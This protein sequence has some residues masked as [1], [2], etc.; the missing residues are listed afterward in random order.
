[1][2]RTHPE[3]PALRITNMQITRTIETSTPVDKV[4]AYL[5]DFTTTNE[6]DPGT[7]ETRRIKGD[8]GVGTDYR[9]TS[10]F[11]GRETEL[12]YTTKELEPGRRIVLEGNNK[13]VRATDTMTLTATA[14][15]GTRVVYNAD[16]DFK[17]VVGKIAPLLSPLLAP[18]FKKL[19]DEAE[20][21]M[22]RALDAL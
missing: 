17:G 10:K 21:E 2:I 1:M 20:V 5:S 4:F 6:W 7:V 12:V 13:T 11:M 18:A 8:G 9:N 3:P 19:G 16:F 14:G 22:G 15:G